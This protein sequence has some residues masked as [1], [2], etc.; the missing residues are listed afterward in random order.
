MAEDTSTETTA[1]DSIF[2]AYKKPEDE[3]SVTEVPDETT[4]VQADAPTD[5]APE[6]DEAQAPEATEPDAERAPEPVEPADAE[7]AQELAPDVAD[8]QSEGVAAPLDASA[9]DASPASEETT[10]AGDA[11]A[12]IDAKPE[13]SE[14]A[15]SDDEPSE[16]PA[17]ADASQAGEPGLGA[18]HAGT[19]TPEYLISNPADPVT[20]LPLDQSN[21]GLVTPP[22]TGG[23]V[24]SPA[25]PQGAVIPGMFGSDDEGNGGGISAPV[26]ADTPA[27]QAPAEASSEQHEAIMDK[28]AQLQDGV[29]SIKASLSALLD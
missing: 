6:A 24:V 16:A 21:S 27:H 13:D 23:G 8:D 11:I 20:G 28:L 26:I 22:I 19:D 5:A 1:P 12:P 4:E 9:T 7:P 14:A 25:S 29:N 17:S 15:K 3:A 10:D 2:D 18:T